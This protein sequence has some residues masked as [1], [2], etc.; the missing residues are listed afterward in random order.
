MY[1]WYTVPLGAMNQY[2]LSQWFPDFMKYNHH[3]DNWLC[4]LPAFLI[5]K[6]FLQCFCWDLYYIFITQ[7]QLLPLLITFSKAVVSNRLHIGIIW[8]TLTKH[9]CSDPIPRDADSIVTRWDPGI[10]SFL[11]LPGGFSKQ[12]GVEHLFN[13]FGEETNG[14]TALWRQPVSSSLSLRRTTAHSLLSTAHVSF[15]RPPVLGTQASCPSQCYYL[16]CWP[17]WRGEVK[18]APQLLCWAAP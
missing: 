1:T 15:L 14:L 11:K 9:R 10:G 18:K 12:P 7:G 8:G 13:L 6:I 2:P 5:Y 3:S 16:C 17:W 4:F